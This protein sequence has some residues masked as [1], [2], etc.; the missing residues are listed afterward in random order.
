MTHVTCPSCSLRFT[1]A[2]AASLLRC[3]FCGGG[4]LVLGAESLVGSQLVEPVVSLWEPPPPGPTDL[5]A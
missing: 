2:S 1:P 4:L 3:P 5:H